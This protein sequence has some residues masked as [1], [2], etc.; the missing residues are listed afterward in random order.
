MVVYFSIFLSP[1]LQTINNFEII[2][3]TIDCI[4]GSVGFTGDFDHLS[5][6]GI[7]ER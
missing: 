6:A 4:S 3:I 7:K 2:Y 1:P 5:D